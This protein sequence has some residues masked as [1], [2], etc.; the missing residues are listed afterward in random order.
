MKNKIFSLLLTAAMVLT[1]ITAPLPK[2]Q[3]IPDD[4]SS[5]SSG[6][7]NSPNCGGEVEDIDG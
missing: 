6:D 1:V 3:P 5:N 7:I 2:P 4:D